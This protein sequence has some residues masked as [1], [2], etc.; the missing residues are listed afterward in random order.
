MK[1]HRNDKFI[2]WGLTI[3]FTFVACALFWIIFSNFKGT[4]DVIMDFIGILAP[5]FYGLVFAYMIDPL[6]KRFRGWFAKLLG[7]TK[8]KEKTAHKL[9]KG[10]AILLGLLTLLFCFYAI[11]ALIVPSLVDSLEYL[12]QQERLDYYFSV[13]DKWIGENFAGTDLAAYLDVNLESLLSV[14]TDLVKKLDFNALFSGLTNSVYT[15][16]RFVFDFIMGIIAAV[17]F[18]IYKEQ[19]LAQ[20]KKIT[21]ALFK[22]SRADRLFEIARRAHRIFTGYVMG[23]IIDSILVG[24]VTYIFLLLMGM[25][26]APMIAVMV[27]VTNII[28][29]FGP[30]LGA[31]PS[32]LLLLLDEPMNAVYFGIFILILQ[33]V[34]GNILY[35]RI[36]GEKIGLSDLWV[37]V[38]VLVGG[39]VFGFGGMLLG[40]P[41]FAL[42]YTLVADFINDRLRKKRFPTVTDEYYAIGCVADLPVE[43]PSS[44]SYVSVDPAYDMQAE[45][46]D[47]LD[48]DDYDDD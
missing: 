13:V 7:K 41:I 42:L 24:V 48:E 5:V 15:V 46:E 29:F 34:E 12:L 20:S 18:L 31:A 35:N 37:L 8:L 2:K 10:I 1:L 39:G 3:F 6:V 23:K 17:Y 40:V 11:V 43:A 30:F 28:P 22:P 16:I 36:I 19:L 27:G 45:P 26:Y 9:S 47:E 38:A 21:V 33:Q 44:Y 25:P 4:Y 32:V 14:V